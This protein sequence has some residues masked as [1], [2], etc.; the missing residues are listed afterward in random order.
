MHCTWLY[1]KF[2]A[3]IIKFFQLQAQPDK[4]WQLQVLTQHNSCRLNLFVEQ[5]W[6]HILTRFPRGLLWHHAPLYWINQD[7]LVTNPI[8]MKMWR[9]IV[10]KKVSFFVWRIFQ[11]QIEQI[12]TLDPLPSSPAPRDSWSWIVQILL[13]FGSPGVQGGGES[14]QSPSKWVP[15]IQMSNQPL[16]FTFP[17]RWWWG[18][19]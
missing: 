9:A 11:K 16:C 10:Q 12:P 18:K 1:V 13:A 7:Y 6:G 15:F 2:Q 5:Q 14:W 4:N 17:L 8:F 19:G 3:K